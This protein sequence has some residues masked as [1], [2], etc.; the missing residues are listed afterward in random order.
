[1]KKKTSRKL[2]IV[3][4]IISLLFFSFII[5]ESQISEESYIVSSISPSNKS[6]E[7]YDF[8]AKNIKIKIPVNFEKIPCR[9]SPRESFIVKQSYCVVEKFNETIEL[10]KEKDIDINKPP[11]SHIKEEYLDFIDL[12]PLEPQ[13]C[14]YFDILSLETLYS[15]LNKNKDIIYF[16]YG[17]HPVYYFD[18]YVLPKLANSVDDLLKPGVSLERTGENTN[19]IDRIII[20]ENNTIVY[21][22]AHCNKCG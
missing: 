2:W 14:A 3:I 20:T 22:Y 15:C 17:E 13:G 7:I 8:I 10:C 5:Y 18:I 4:I 1:M 21:T 16:F 19:D 12:S 9:F 6:C 11:L